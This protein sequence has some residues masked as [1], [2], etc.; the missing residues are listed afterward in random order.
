[1]ER[2]SIDL[3]GQKVELELEWIDAENPAA[4]LIIFLHEGLGSARMWGA[5]PASLCQVLGCRGLVYSRYGYGDSSSRPAQQAWP[6]DYMEVEARIVL[7]ALL[8][9]LGIDAQKNPPILFGHSDGASIALLYAAAMPESVAGLIVLAPHVKVDGAALSGVRKLL[10]NYPN[11][12]L[13]T[14]LAHYHAEPEALFRGWSNCWLAPGFAGWD[15]S[16]QLARIKC[17]TLAIQGAQ[18]QYGGS[19][20]LLAIARHV[21]RSRQAILLNCRHVPHEEQPHAVLAAVMQ[22]LGPVGA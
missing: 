6:V 13:R 5:W 17:P 19:E 12:R 8:R 21:E 7:P 18:D 9:T 11:G 16:P 2:R 22:F 3:Q 4:P 1:L 10:K 20:H 14:R 15:I